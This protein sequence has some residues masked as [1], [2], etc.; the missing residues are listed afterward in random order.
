MF[1]SA[2]SGFILFLISICVGPFILIAAF[3]TM[4]GQRVRLPSLIK[5][6]L[7]TLALLGGMLMETAGMVAHIVAEQLPARYAHL[8]PV[9]KPFLKYGIVCLCVLLAVHCLCAQADR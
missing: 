4:S 6:I 5:P 8:K 2:I 1:T 9:A 3:Q 7:Q